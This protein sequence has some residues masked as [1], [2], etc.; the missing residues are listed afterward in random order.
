MENLEDWAPLGKRVKL[1]SVQIRR[2]ESSHTRLSH[3]TSV[4][5]GIPFVPGDG[6]NITSKIKYSFPSQL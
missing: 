1:V 3:H 6:D 4:C 2:R 5:G